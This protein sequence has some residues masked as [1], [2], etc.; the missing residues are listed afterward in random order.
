MKFYTPYQLKIAQG[1][2]SI[3]R[4]KGI[5]NEC[6]N[7]FKLKLHTIDGFYSDK[8]FTNDLRNVFECSPK[9]VY[10]IINRLVQL[11]F[12]KRNSNGYAVVSYD[13]FYGILGYDMTR[14]IGKSDKVRLGS[15]KMHK[16]YKGQVVTNI[17]DCIDLRMIM[18]DL[19]KQLHCIK[20]KLSKDLRV[21]NAVPIN[22]KRG[23]KAKY[24]GLSLKEKA[25]K[26]VADNLIHIDKLNQS[27]KLI[28]DNEAELEINTILASKLCNLDI[29][30][31]IRGIA[32]LLGCSI[33][34]AFYLIERMIKADKV[35]SVPRQY[36]IEHCSSYEYFISNYDP[37][38]YRYRDM[39]IYKVM[40]NKLTILL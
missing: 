30:L 8:T 5:L 9:H 27:G 23:K 29:T 15:F 17:K 11:G 7:Y 21:K 28:F 22:L 26:Y 18:V 36:F 31:S 34:Y 10:N 19:K 14:T 38:Y 3:A 2:S 25:N 16:I 37:R 33:S 35:K 32:N 24:V 20:R 12:V 1:L 40:A 6:V 39:G 13:K 4:E